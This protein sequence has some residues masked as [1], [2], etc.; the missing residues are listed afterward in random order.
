[1]DMKIIFHFTLI[2]DSPEWVNMAAPNT[3]AKGV[4]CL[5]FV[6]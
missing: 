2:Y 4:H 6:P 3:A 1:M 5:T